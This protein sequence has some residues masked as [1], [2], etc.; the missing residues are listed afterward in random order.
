MLRSCRRAPVAPAAACHR[1]TRLCRKLKRMG[2]GGPLLG[3]NKGLAEK[4]TPGV[5]P[6]RNYL[7][8]YQRYSFIVRFA[9][10]VFFLLYGILSILTRGSWL[11]EMSIESA[12]LQGYGSALTPAEYCILNGLPF[13]KRDRSAVGRRFPRKAIAVPIGLCCSL[14]EARPG[15]PAGGHTARSVGTFVWIFMEAS[16]DL[17]ILIR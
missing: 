13:R 6:L 2:L 9:W 8:F 11:S 14:H 4:Q 12:H 15:F 17:Q 16:G 7:Q 10:F 1:A 3:Q 5:Y